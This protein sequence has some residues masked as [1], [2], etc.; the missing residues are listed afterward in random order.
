MITM[1]INFTFVCQKREHSV[2]KG[3]TCSFH[4]ASSRE[5]ILLS[6][7]VFTEQ[8]T[9]SFVDFVIKYQRDGKRPPRILLR[10]LRQDTEH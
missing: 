9:N 4:F 6:M 2:S 10:A 8:C 1:C 7:K 3:R 5:K